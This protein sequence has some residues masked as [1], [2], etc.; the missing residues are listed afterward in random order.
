NA[1]RPTRERRHGKTARVAEPVQHLASRGER[2]YPLPVVALVEKE[3]GLLSAFDVDAEIDAV[4][5]DRTA[6]RLFVSSCET[7]PGFKSL[8]AP[9]LRIRALVDRLATR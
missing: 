4:L 3:T 1:G 9:H 8:Q 7:R 2:A 6:P 5:D